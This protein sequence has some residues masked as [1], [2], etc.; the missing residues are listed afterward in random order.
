[1][2]MAAKQTKTETRVLRAI[3]RLQ[4]DGLTDIGVLATYDRL[5]DETMASRSA[6]LN[7]CQK[8]VKGGKLLRRKVNAGDRARWERFWPSGFARRQ[9]HFELSPAMLEAMEDDGLEA[10]PDKDVLGKGALEI[11]ELANGGYRTPE[12]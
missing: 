11:V 5:M 1:M 4:T 3:F 6:L 10:M 2:S 8:L 7:A 12:D 9:A